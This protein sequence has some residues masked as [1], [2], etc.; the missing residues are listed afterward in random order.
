MIVPNSVLFRKV[1]PEDCEALVSFFIKNAVPQ[2]TNTFTAFPLTRKIAEW[3]SQTE[4]KD[5]YYLLLVDQQIACLS[6]LR[7]FD[8]GFTIPSFGIMI[9]HQYQNMGYGKQLLAYTIDQ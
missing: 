8:E 6:M 5:R 3:I 7:G 9:G 4:H 1:L 2:V